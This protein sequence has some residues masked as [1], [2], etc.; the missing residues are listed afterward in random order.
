VCLAWRHSYWD[1]NTPR[2]PYGEASAERDTYHRYR[3]FSYLDLYS[4]CGTL[5]AEWGTDFCAFTIP[6]SGP[7]RSCL[8]PIV[9]FAYRPTPGLFYTNGFGCG[10]CVYW[11]PRALGG[12]YPVRTVEVIARYWILLA[13][14]WLPVAVWL[15]RV[16][17][18]MRRGGYRGRR[19]RCPVCDYDL[20]ATPGRCPECGTAAAATR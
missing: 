3:S 20:R 9:P 1:Y 6:L 7:P 14:A 10:I 15:V 12:G 11:K 8:G 13:I 2:H 19:G 18:R 5:D 16:G 17:L 4:Q